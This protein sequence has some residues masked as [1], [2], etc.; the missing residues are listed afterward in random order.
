MQRIIIRHLSG[1]KTNQV[2]EFPLNHFS[3]IVLGRDPSATVKYDPDRDDLVGRQHAR[4]AADPSDATQYTVTDLNSRN[5]TYVNKQRIVTATKIAPG[6]QIQLGPGGPEFQFDL[7]PRPESTVK[8][9][10]SAALDALSPTIQGASGSVPSTRQVDL[11]MPPTRSVNIGAP[12][13]STSPTGTVGKAT[14]ERMI[15]QNIAVTKRTEGRKYMMVG[16]MGLAAVVI[17]FTAVAGYLWYRNKTSESQL[18][19]VLQNTP[20]SATAIAQSKGNAVVMIEV[21]WKL[22][23]PDG[24]LV[25]HKGGCP[26]PCFIEVA[27]GVI[28]PVLATEEYRSG[29]RPINGTFTAS[30]F[31]V[32]NDGFILTNRHV[33]YAWKSVYPFQDMG[34]LYKRNGTVEAIDPARPA[35]N[36]VPESTTL[37]KQA[38]FIGDLMQMSKNNKKNPLRERGA[39]SGFTGVNDKLEVAF[40]GTSSRIAAQLVRAADDQDVAMIKI[41]VPDSTPKVDPYDNYESIKQGD[42]A[43]VMGYPETSPPIY[44]FAK[45]AQINKARFREIPDPT[46]SVGNIGRLIRPRKEMAGKRETLNVYGDAFQLSVSSTG[47]SNSGGPVFDDRGRVIGIFTAPGNDSSIA[48]AIPI[49][50]G[51]ELMSVGASGK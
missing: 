4:I 7:E 5:G 46:V 10:R 3:E 8:S 32:S 33:V 24:G 2:E 28:E 29:G 42:T 21:S 26:G 38:D 43:I 45:Q 19:R 16:G 40:P 51:Q 39:L 34:T 49:R 36:W 48:F 11:G 20:M 37:E 44:G 35:I 6:D 23:A 13:G 30:G 22:I 18:S 9:T 25:Y 1:S 47:Y 31:V 14:V 50:Y 41:S 17:L 15:S 27:E 12:G